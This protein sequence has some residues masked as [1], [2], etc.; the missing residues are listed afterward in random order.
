MLLIRTH[1]GTFEVAI[2]QKKVA[3]AAAVVAAT[4][5]AKKPRPPLERKVRKSQTTPSNLPNMFEQRERREAEFEKA[6]MEAKYVRISSAR[7]KTQV[8]SVTFLFQEAPRTSHGQEGADQR[9]G[10]I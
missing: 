3:S 9:P 10:Q 5:G 6:K 4:A 8:K 1:S 2:A 7:S